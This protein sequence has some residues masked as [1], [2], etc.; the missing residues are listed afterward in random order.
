MDGQILH[1]PV[2]GGEYKRV[3][4]YGDGS[5]FFHSLAVTMYGKAYEELKKKEQVELGHMV[6]Q[7]ILEEGYR[8][9]LEEQGFLGIEGVVQPEEAGQV[10]VQADEAIINFAAK[11]LNLNLC[12]LVSPTEKYV[13]EVD[14]TKPWILLGWI[15]RM[16][17]EPIVYV[18]EYSTFAVE[19]DLI[20]VSDQHYMLAC[21]DPMVKWIKK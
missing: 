12:I 9:F 1:S 2:F 21:S 3:Y 7:R 4:T 5:C 16:H 10:D 20:N 17:F 18:N 13:R 8:E 14:S 6:R 19:N 15:K 11:R